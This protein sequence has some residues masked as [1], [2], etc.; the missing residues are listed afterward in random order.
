[1]YPR[2]QRA[3]PSQSQAIAA[4]D[5]VA[6]AQNRNTEFVPDGEHAWRIW[7]EHALTYVAVVDET[8]E[9]AILAFPCL[10]GRLFIHKVMV[11]EALR[12]Q[13][14]GGQLFAV[15]LEETDRLQVDTFLTVDPINDRAIQLYRKW[16]FEE[17]AREKDY[18][19]PGEDRLI[20]RRVMGTGES[21]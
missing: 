4:L 12:G 19:S 16:G 21:Q 14:I 9:G 5:R 15:L 13:G 20:L 6:W 1:M 11:G 17:Q 7:C 8:V 18:Y 10:D 3:T 2:I